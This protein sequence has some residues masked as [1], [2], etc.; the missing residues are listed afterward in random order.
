[1]A[2]ISDNIN[3]CLQCV[4]SKS[5]PNILAVNI[6]FLIADSLKVGQISLY[7]GY[8]LHAEKLRFRRRAYIEPAWGVCVQISDLLSLLNQS[9]LA[10]LFDDKADILRYKEWALEA[11]GMNSEVRDHLIM[12][13]YE[14]FLEESIDALKCMES[15][16]SNYETTS[17]N[18]GPYPIESFPFHYYAPEV[19]LL[20]KKNSHVDL[21]LTKDIGD[22]VAGLIVEL[23][24]VD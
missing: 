15:L 19:L 9:L 12:N 1:M 11:F 17:G 16:R 21:D 14:F 24:M 5:A 22:E 10:S 7:E 23:G 18:N 8:L 20:N 6:G 4:F 3:N 13:D 2:K